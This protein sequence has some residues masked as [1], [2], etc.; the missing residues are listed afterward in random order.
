MFNDVLSSTGAEA[1]MRFIVDEEATI[2]KGIGGTDIIQGAIY[3]VNG[4]LVGK[5]LDVNT[6]PKG[7]YYVDGKKVAI[8]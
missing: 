7:I 4:Q 2:I 5:D 3:N 8:F 6:L 1:K